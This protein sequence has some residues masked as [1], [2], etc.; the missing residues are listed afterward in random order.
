MSLLLTLNREAQERVIAGLSYVLTR[1]SEHSRQSLLTGLQRLHQRQDLDV[2]I[3]GY[4]TAFDQPE[5]GLAWFKKSYNGVHPANY[6]QMAT[7]FGA[8]VY[9]ARLDS[10]S[11]HT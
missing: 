8:L 2:V 6:P 7:M 4:N 3:I 1:H 9:D 10:W 5:F 11:V